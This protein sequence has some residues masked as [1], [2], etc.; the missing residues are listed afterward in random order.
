MSIKVS[1]GNVVYENEN[2]VHPQNDVSL[3]VYIKY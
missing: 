3:Y 1:Y 2:M